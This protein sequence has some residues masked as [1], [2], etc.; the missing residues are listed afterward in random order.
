MFKT[1]KGNVPN[2]T[3]T[4]L[5]IIKVKTKRNGSKGDCVNNFVKNLYAL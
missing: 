1:I 4:D 5:G 3:I 2:I